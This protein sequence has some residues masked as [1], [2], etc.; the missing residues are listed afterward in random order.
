MVS[1]YALAKANDEVSV[2]RT[3]LILPKC[4]S[5]SVGRASPCQGE[6]RRFEPGLPLQNGN[7]QSVLEEPSH[8][9][10]G[11]PRACGYR[12]TAITSDFQSEDGS[13][14]LP[15]RSKIM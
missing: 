15:I 6:G 13:S 9:S 4:G 14:I 8:L 12:I 11:N 7:L 1:R 3:R 2:G 10:K 5:S